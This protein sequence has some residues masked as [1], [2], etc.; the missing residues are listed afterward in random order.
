M[1]E[2]V[3]GALIVSNIG[4]IGSFIYF[5]GRVIWFFSAL[6]SQVENHET[7]IIKL[8]KKAGI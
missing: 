2:Y 5:A 8:E 6:N 1:M 3:I 7:R 4:I